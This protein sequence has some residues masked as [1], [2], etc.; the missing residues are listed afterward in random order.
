[1]V[2]PC[3]MLLGR[4]VGV[5]KPVTIR[6]LVTSV[7]SL[8]WHSPGRWVMAFTCWML[9]G[10]AV[11]VCKP[12]TTRG[13]VISELIFLTCIWAEL[14]VVDGKEL[15][16]FL[17]TATDM[18]ICCVALMDDSSRAFT[19]FFWFC[20]DTDFTL[21]VPKFWFRSKRGVVFC[22]FVVLLSLHH[23]NVFA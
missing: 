21:A 11:G 1:M 8:A 9:L 14:R 17:L 7:L 19:A 18:C 3:E 5:C 22:C 4:A 6:G 13:A 2:L 12:V 15:G 23:L 10:R 20:A 16:K